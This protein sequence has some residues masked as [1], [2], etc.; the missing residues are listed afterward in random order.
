M[1][2]TPV[3]LLLVVLALSWTAARATPEAERL[4]AEAAAAEAALQ[5]ARAVELYL[6]AERLR[7]DDARLLQ[8]IAR[9][10]SDLME[11]KSDS[12]ER[13]DLA[14]RA[15]TYAERA[16]TLAPQDAVVALSVAICHAKLGL[17]S[18]AREKVAL[19]RVVR[20]EA[21]RAL[22]LD[23]SYAWAHHVLG[24]WHHEISALGRVARWWVK[25][26]YG[27]LPEASPEAGLRHLRRAVELEPG[28][29]AHHVE[30]GLALAD[31]GRK[32][33][34]RATLERA[35]A[36]PVTSHHHAAVLRRA[37]EALAAWGRPSAG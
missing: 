25:T 6:A 19:S 11:E 3:R 22:A 30:L 1:R 23:P 5:P 10:Y 29:S 14:R 13:R 20:D 27:G 16:R 15:L 7:P 32:E 17:E 36:F 21:E 18:P 34:A 37:R 2:A 35:L 24:R 31:A 4:L 12:T 33:E 9:Q 26:F 8:K 28:E